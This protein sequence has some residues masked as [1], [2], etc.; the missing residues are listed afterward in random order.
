M[1]IPLY[2]KFLMA[3]IIFGAAGFITIATL[4]SGLTYNYLIRAKSS[5]LKDE[6]GLIA[7]TY[8]SVY[9]GQDIELEDAYPQIQMAASFLH[10]QIWV[11]GRDGT[12]IVDTENKFKKKC[13]Q[14]F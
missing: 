6:A 9:S 7:T 14:R 12:I 13:N 1:K 2:I 3:Y 8:S 11:I 4:S 5:T 10:S